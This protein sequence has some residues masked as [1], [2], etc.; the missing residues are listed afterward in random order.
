MAAPML[1]LLQLINA[2]QAGQSIESLKFYATANGEL[3]SAFGVRAGTQG[4]L[5]VRRRRTCGCGGRAGPDRTY[6]GR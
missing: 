5:V 4:L 6:E 2:P 1:D 3:Q